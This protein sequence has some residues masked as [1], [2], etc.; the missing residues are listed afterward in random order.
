MEL[1][2]T[3]LS[4]SS[5]QLPEEIQ[6]HASVALRS[7]ITRVIYLESAVTER[8]IIRRLPQVPTITI[9]HDKLQTNAHRLFQEWRAANPSGY[10]INCKGPKNSLLHDAACSHLGDTDWGGEEYSTL[11]DKRKVCARTTAELRAWATKHH[12]RIGEC[13]H[14][15]RRGF[16]DKAMTILSYRSDPRLA[17]CPQ[18]FL[19]TGT[20]KDDK[21]NRGLLAK[22]QT[23]HWRVA[24]GR[25]QNG[26]AIFVLL[27][28]LTTKGGYPRELHA[29]VVIGQ[30]QK[31]EYHG[32]TLFT[33]AEFFSL[34][35]I[36]Q[37]VKNFLIDRVPPQ[38]NRAL[39]IWTSARSL[40]ETQESFSS[41][42][43]KASQDS[44]AQ[45]KARLRKAP[46]FP[47]R[48]IVTTEVFIRNQDVVA[49]VL[50]QARGICGLCDKPAPFFRRD[51]GSPY[52]EVHHK[53]HLAKGGE[54]TVENAIALCPNC[55]RKLHHG[56][57]EA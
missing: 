28:A 38:G 8:R 5:S 47:G 48:I 1:G 33:V 29:G 54:D 21:Y 20:Q 52:L 17:A 15:K 14:C 53:I 49:E 10:F 25:I 39:E 36:G 43:R 55:H 50:S 40:T 46:R 35:S 27:P 2:K 16:D 7:E 32:R 13:K 30:K 34:P 4:R 44:S 31:Q 51:D 26:D 41:S 9:F 24:D 6:P 19:V 12:L 18:A 42:I 37:D 23:G 57:S 45:R 3:I 11:A 22:R 56:T